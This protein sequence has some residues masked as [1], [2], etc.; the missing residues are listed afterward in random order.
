MKHTSTIDKLVTDYALAK[1]FH[2]IS[3]SIGNIQNLERQLNNLCNQDK[4]LIDKYWRLDHDNRDV[5]AR[6]NAYKEVQEHIDKLEAEGKSVFFDIITN[7]LDCPEEQ[8]GLFA[9]DK[10]G[11][12]CYDWDSYSDWNEYGE[13]FAVMVRYSLENIEQSAPYISLKSQIEQEKSKLD[14]I[15]EQLTMRG[16]SFD[17]A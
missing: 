8:Q 7:K 12:F 13:I 16:V 1:Y 9:W 6:L 2:D 11:L 10:D 3:N 5:E 4:Y 17:E 15:I 14:Y